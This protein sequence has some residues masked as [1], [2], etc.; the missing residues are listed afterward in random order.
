MTSNRPAG[1]PSSGNSAPPTSRRSARQQRLA[2]REANRAITRASTRGSDGGGMSSLLL[3]SVVA[4]VVAVVVVGGLLLVSQSKSNNSGAPTAPGVVTPTTITSNDRTL[5]N[6]NAP[7]TIDLWGDFRCS[8]CLVFTVEGTE[9]NI[10]DNYV[11]TGK[12]K[13]VWHDYTIIDLKDGTTASRDAANAGWCAADQ[14]RFWTLHD[15]MYANQGP[16]EDAANF[17][18]SRLAEM[19]KVAGLD[20][21]KFQPC[22]D[23]GTHNDAIAA[24]QTSKPAE[25][26]GT[27]T[28]FVNGKL[29]VKNGQSSTAYADIKAAIDAA[30]ASPGASGS[31]APSA[32]AAPAAAPSAT[33]VPS[34]SPSAKSS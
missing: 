26:A 16:N 15:W 24:E 34:V 3:W 30:L 33:A 6:A 14:N 8:A 11:A 1:R 32:S 25:V 13:L 19:A 21:A 27:P 10:V 2:N 20:M 31:A 4:V 5:G 9:K 12:A 23:G 29:V 18:K 7:V 28:L 17:T 22:L